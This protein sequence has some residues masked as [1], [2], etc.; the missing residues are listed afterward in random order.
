VTTKGG[1]IADWDTLIDRFISEEIIK[2]T[3]NPPKA[4]FL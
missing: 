4:N 2:D 1:Q 3:P